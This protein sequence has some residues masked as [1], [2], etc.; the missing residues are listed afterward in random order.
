MFKNDVLIF[1]F[2]LLVSAKEIE[3]FVNLRVSNKSLFSGQRN[4]SM[5]GWRYESK[6]KL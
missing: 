1:Y 5:W 4:A 2:L 6:L 3:D